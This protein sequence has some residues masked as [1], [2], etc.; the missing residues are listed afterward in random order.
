MVSRCVTVAFFH[1]TLHIVTNKKDRTSCRTSAE[2]NRHFRLGPTEVY[3]SSIS[4]ISERWRVCM[5]HTASVCG[6]TAVRRHSAFAL[7]VFCTVYAQPI[8]ALLVTNDVSYVAPRPFFYFFEPLEWK[9]IKAY[10]MPCYATLARPFISS[11]IKSIC[12]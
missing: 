11:S 1:I 3:G 4:S 2:L 12:V 5:S 7:A 8:G 10:C 6:R 9:C